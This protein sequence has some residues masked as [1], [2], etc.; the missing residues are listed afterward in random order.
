MLALAGYMAAD[1]YGIPGW[2]HPGGYP[3][4]R[5][6]REGGK[7]RLRKE[8]LRAR[9][10]QGTFALAFAQCDANAIRAVVQGVLADFSS[11]AAAPHGDTA[12]FSAGIAAG[13]ED[14]DDAEALVCAAFERMV[15]AKVAG[16]DR[17]VS[18]GEP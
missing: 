11:S 15:E 2:V 3:Y 4:L 13:P 8:D 7:S 6:K 9:L 10:D 17:V 14:G 5:T 1:R 16:R 12:T 18:G